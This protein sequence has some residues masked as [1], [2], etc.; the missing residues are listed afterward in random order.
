MTQE[1]INIIEKYMSPEEIKEIITE[2]LRGKLKRDFD[3]TYDRTLLSPDAKY[4]N[5]WAFRVF[6]EFFLENYK[7]NLH[8]VAKASLDK[9]EIAHVLG[10][11][12]DRKESPETINKLDGMRIVNKAFEESKEEI[13]GIIMSALK[14]K[15]D[16]YLLEML[17]DA[18]HQ[19]M[20]SILDNLRKS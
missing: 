4:V 8:S 13:K 1:E 16:D 3:E 7:T 2:E 19:H 9:F 20:F 5:N 10:H 14:E 6:G 17:T 12:W 15:D 18:Y 11:T